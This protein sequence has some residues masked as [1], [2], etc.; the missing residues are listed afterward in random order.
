MLSP[1]QIFEDNIRPAE[2]LLKV[3]RL[4]EHDTPCTKAEVVKGLREI[5]KASEE[6]ALI[7]IYNEKEPAAPSTEPENTTRP[8][9]SNASAPELSEDLHFMKHCCSIC[10]KPYVNPCR[11]MIMEVCHCV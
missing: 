5:V 7:V 3:Y 6:E 9:V 8:E 10:G 4:L 2:L 1:R 11:I